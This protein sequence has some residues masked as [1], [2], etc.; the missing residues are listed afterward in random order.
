MG[1]V[2]H[3]SYVGPDQIRP[4]EPALRLR[5]PSGT[6]LGSRGSK[7]SF[8]NVRGHGWRRTPKIL[9][10]RPIAYPLYENT[11]FRR[12]VHAHDLIS[13]LEG[14]ATLATHFPASV[15]LRPFRTLLGTPD[16]TPAYQPYT[17]TGEYER[18]YLNH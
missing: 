2:R 4:M 1:T 7:H 12:A 10:S 17:C 14:D 18:S 15:Q 6:L 13:P 8:V 3:R 9:L 5:D 16:L 11:P